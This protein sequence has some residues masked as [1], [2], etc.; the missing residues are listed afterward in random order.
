MADKPSTQDTI[1][2]F[3]SDIADSSNRAFNEFLDPPNKS[4]K[5][6]LPDWFPSG[7][8]L[9]ALAGTP[10][11]ALQALAA[12]GAVNPMAA[13]AGANPF[14]TLADTADRNSGA[15]NPLGVLAGA[16]N[17]LAALAGAVNPVAALSGATAPANPLSAFG[18]LAGAAAALPASAAALP[19]SAGALGGLAESLATLPQQIARL[20]ELLSTLVGALDAVRDV[21]ETAGVRPPSKK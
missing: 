5:S 8:P 20:T 16:A 14:A 2:N 4:N 13:L 21:A 6:N 1:K 9:A 10:V 19:A 15:V 17:P 3:L 18:Q 11:G 7:H 12:F